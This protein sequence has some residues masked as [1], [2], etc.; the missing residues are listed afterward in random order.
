[1]HTEWHRVACD[2]DPF[3]YAVRFGVSAK[4]VGAGKSRREGCR[5]DD[6]DVAGG[7]VGDAA[8]VCATGVSGH[9]ADGRERGGRERA[10]GGL[11]GVAGDAVEGVVLEDAVVCEGL[12]G[13][14]RGGAAAGCAE[15]LEG[16]GGGEDGSEDGAD[17]DDEEGRAG[18]GGKSVGS[19]R[20]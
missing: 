12:D 18:H 10:R 15:E 3:V 16:E 13:G 4:A 6:L 17:D 2:G 5:K 20:T 14:Q 9:V 1:M 19:A 11:E 7:G 8:G